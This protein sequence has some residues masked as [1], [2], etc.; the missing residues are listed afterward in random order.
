MKIRVKFLVIFFIVNSSLRTVH[1]FAQ[2]VI[3]IVDPYEMKVS[4]SEKAD[5][6][7]FS[8]NSVSGM[9]K[10]K[11]DT[12][13][14]YDVF[15]EERPTPF[16]KAYMCNGTEVTKQKYNN[17]KLLWNASGACKP[18]MLYTY[19]DKEQL[20][21][22]AYQYEDCLCGS[23]IEYYS[24]GSKKLEGQFKG[25]STGNW[26]NLK[27]RNVCNI[28]DGLWTYYLPN[29][30]PEKTETYMD[31]KLKSTVYAV[32]NSSASKKINSF[33]SESSD[34]ESSPKKGLIQRM[35]DKNIPTDN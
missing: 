1:C 18:C 17:Y 7:Y 24:E 20:K 27:Y 31:G 11:L 16:G 34:V 15:L 5:T 3:D 23:Y 12:I 22:I 21:H 29:G 19:D 25:N 2:D 8:Q 28:R 4:R 13:R 26:E 9:A 14:T 32:Q 10:Q 33:K 6:F 30:I 35:K